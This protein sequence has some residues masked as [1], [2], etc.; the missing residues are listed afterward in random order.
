[1]GRCDCCV[2]AV[3][4][5]GS[6]TTLWVGATAAVTAVEYSGSETTLWVG[7][8]AAVKTVECSGTQ[9]TASDHQSRKLGFQSYAVMLNPRL[10]CSF[11]VAP[12]HL[13]V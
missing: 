12:V 2:T 10:V 11:S 8:T 5:S 7:A 1:M 13:A 9:T 3:E 4:C 6:E